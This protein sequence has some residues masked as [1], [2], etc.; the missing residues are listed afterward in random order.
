MVV[1]HSS[2]EIA[3]AY[4]AGLL[5]E[6][7]AIMVAFYRGYVVTKIT[8][9]GSML[10]VG[11]GAE[12]AEAIIDQMSLR[13]E[14]C[15]ACVSSSESVT[16]SGRSKGI[17][18]LMSELE[19][20]SVFARKLATGGRAY[21]SFLMKEIGAEYE[22]LV[23]KAMTVL[24]MPSSQTDD[25]EPVR[26][27]SSVGKGSDALPSFSRETNRFIRPGYWRANLEN[28]VQFNTAIK[29]IVATGKHH[30]HEIGPHSALQLPVKQIRSFL[31]LS[32]D[33]LSYASTLARGKNT[34]TSMKIL[35]GQLYL[36]GHYI[37]FLA[38]NNTGNKNNA[39]VV[40]DL[41][42]YH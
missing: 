22:S 23:S 8:S 4:A 33:D 29:N 25:K 41:P 1:G 21:H 3:A 6:A 27:F 14:L 5:T 26:F 12:D 36:T 7:Q 16:I 32:E 39:S 34:D 37:D 10:A 40:H 11:M 18:K 13:E 35:A 17:D 19:V 24:P 30:L 28:P 2:G 42:P 20:K 31:G 15:V 38:V 9:K